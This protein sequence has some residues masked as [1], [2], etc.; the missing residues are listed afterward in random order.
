MLC[1]KFVEQ[2]TLPDANQVKDAKKPK[3]D[4]VGGTPTGD[5]LD[6]TPWDHGSFV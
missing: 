2:K 6:V 3:N 5:H 4:Q 1:C